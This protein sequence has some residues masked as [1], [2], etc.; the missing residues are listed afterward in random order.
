MTKAQE[1][2][3]IVIDY[4]DFYVSEKNL[5]KADYCNKQYRQ[6]IDSFMNVIPKAT[7]VEFGQC[8]HANSIGNNNEYPLV[9]KSYDEDGFLIEK[10]LG[11]FKYVVGVYG[12]VSAY[13]TDNFGNTLMKRGRAR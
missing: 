13:I 7:D 3:S 6:Q 9:I 4:F 10:K 12:G 8:Y 2:L 1:L 5:L 11:T